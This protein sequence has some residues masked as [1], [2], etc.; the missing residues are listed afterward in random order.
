MQIFGWN[1]YCYNDDCNQKEWKKQGRT[2]KRQWTVV[3]DV[4]LKGEKN[5]PKCPYCHK[6]MTITANSS[7]SDFEY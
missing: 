1:C 7:E 2:G 4:M 3:S 6:Y 5:P